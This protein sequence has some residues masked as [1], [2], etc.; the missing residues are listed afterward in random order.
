M[1]VRSR[2]RGPERC[3][4]TVMTAQVRRNDDTQRYELVDGDRVLGF[5]EFRPAITN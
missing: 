1:K 4:M 3:R 2:R 5:A